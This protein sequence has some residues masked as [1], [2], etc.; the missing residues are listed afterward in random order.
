MHGVVEIQS[1]GQLGQVVGS[2]QGLA[3][4]MKPQMVASCPAPIPGKEVTDTITFHE[5]GGST[6]LARLKPS[7]WGQVTVTRDGVVIEPTLDPGDLDSVVS[8]VLAATG[9]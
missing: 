1:R 6:V 8:E 4:S 5:S 7:C 2:F 3:A 9:G